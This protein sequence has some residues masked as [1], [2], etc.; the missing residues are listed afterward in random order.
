[1]ATIRRLDD[2]VSNEL[3]DEFDQRE[4]ETVRTADVNTT[5]AD[6]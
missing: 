5:D 3:L 4:L 2:A 6:A 1:M